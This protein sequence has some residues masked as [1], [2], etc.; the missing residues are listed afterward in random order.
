MARSLHGNGC[1]RSKLI[2]GL[3]RRPPINTMSSK[4]TVVSAWYR[5]SSKFP[6]ATYQ[7]W[8]KNFFRMGCNFLVFTDETS[9]ADLPENVQCII[10][11][12]EN[13]YTSRWDPY[14]EW[15]EKIDVEKKRGVNH[16][17]DLYKIW[18]EK[19]FFMLE[20]ATKNLF[21]GDWFCW[22]DIG[23]LREED[24][25][26]TACGFPDGLRFFPSDKV[27]LSCVASPEQKD[28]NM[29]NG[30]SQ[31][32]LNTGP[33]SSCENVIRIQ[34]GFFAGT[35]EPLKK[36]AAMYEA[37]LQLWMK[38]KIFAGKDQYV[39]Y[40]MLLKDR[41]G[42]FCVL[43]PSRREYKN[44]WFSFIPRCSNVK[45][46]SAKI[47]GG[48]GN[49]MFQVAAAWSCAL[50]NNGIAIFD[51]NSPYTQP[52]DTPR[53]GYWTTVFK[54]F[55]T[56]EGIKPPW[57][58]QNE[59]WNHAFTHLHG[60][61]RWN[62]FVGYFQSSQ[63]FTPEIKNQFTLP[64]AF[65][66]NFLKH[67]PKPITAVH[68]RLGD[69]KKLGWCLPPTYYET[70]LSKISG[71][72][73]VVSDEPEEAKKILPSAIICDSGTDEEQ[74]AL[75]SMSDNLVMSNSSFSWWAAYLGSHNRVFAPN[76]WF[77][78]ASFC[79]EIWEEHWEKISV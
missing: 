14:W 52:G 56:T 20:A 26:Q 51:R 71:T 69:Y 1:C 44:E 17:K 11:P 78:N 31:I 39:M 18:N 70:A 22:C 21:N 5:I 33:E 2:L 45:I 50:Q 43:P 79:P 53:D 23:V 6:S 35:T 48:L 68:V 49:Q 75:L 15:C 8:I 36:Y 28:Q 58:D 4:V 12:L 74:M 41:S 63:Y 73:I 46:F 59:H 64:K 37:E 66:E 24:C 65:A 67:L 13:F 32:F 55:H 40:N 30:I 19:P 60:R 54:K 76:P 3:K 42:T 38:E 62:R 61:E 47:Q 9:K 57:V 10:K 77:K 34:G 72:I 7:T 16:T 29:F 27:V 25:V